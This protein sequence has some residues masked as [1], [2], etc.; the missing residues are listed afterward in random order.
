MKIAIISDTHGKL[1]E[2]IAALLKDY[3]QILHA[4]DLDTQ[5]MYERIRGL[6]PAVAAVRG[7]CDWWAYGDIL[8]PFR[9]MTFQGIRIFMTHRPQDV[10]SFMNRD[11]DIVICGHTHCYRDETVGA[12]RYVNPGSVSEPRD[13]ER[14]F[15][16]LK[17]G[18]NGYS[19]RHILPDHIASEP[20]GVTDVKGGRISVLPTDP[21]NITKLCEYC[22]GEPLRMVK[23]IMKLTDRGKDID[24]VSERLAVPKE[25]VER[26]VRLYLTHPGIDADGV[27]NK[28][29][30]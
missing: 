9:S 7:N 12:V 20:P 13:G 1:K 22:N 26:I 8:P 17:I 14:G 23:N 11:H 27:L 3:D 29:G 6:G 24:T 2:D 28:M 4:G 5:D 15:L 25:L 19:L 10:R 18:E 30:I 21:V 16:E